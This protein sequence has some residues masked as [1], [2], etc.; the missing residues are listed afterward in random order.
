MVIHRGNDPDGVWPEEPRHSR[1]H[2]G[3]NCGSFLPQSGWEYEELQDEEGRYIA[4]FTT[5]P[6]CGLVVVEEK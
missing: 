1:K 4:W 2:Y 3:A 6:R 5:C